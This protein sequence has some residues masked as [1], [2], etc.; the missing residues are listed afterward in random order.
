MT[1][2]F[3][4]FHKT[5]VRLTKNPKQLTFRFLSLIKSLCFVETEHL[6]W[7]RDENSSSKD[8]YRIIHDEEE[9]SLVNLNKK[10]SNLAFS[11]KKN[12]KTIEI[13]ELLFKLIGNSAK[14]KSECPLTAKYFKE[15][16]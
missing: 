7:D 3:D 13:D 10:R 9:E 11:S 5:F 1:L 4:R 6:K 2:N 8:F 16:G 12:P 14:A 15:F